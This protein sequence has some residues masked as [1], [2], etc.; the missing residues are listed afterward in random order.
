MWVL[1]WFFRPVALVINLLLILLVLLRW[2]LLRMSCGIISTWRCSTVHL[3]QSI[4]QSLFRARLLD[5]AWA[6]K[7]TDWLNEWLTEWMTDWV[8]EWVTLG[9]TCSHQVYLCLYYSFA[10]IAFAS[11]TPIC[12]SNQIGVARSKLNLEH[13]CG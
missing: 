3:P 7:L 13:N 2:L 12:M 4:R 11:H 1:K 10:S 8:S 9:Y 5:S 6:N